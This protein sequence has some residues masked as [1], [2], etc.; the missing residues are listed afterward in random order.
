MALYLSQLTDYIA[1]LRIEYKDMSVCMD[2]LE[3]FKWDNVLVPKEILSE[4]A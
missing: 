3:P 4:G 2:F 1:D